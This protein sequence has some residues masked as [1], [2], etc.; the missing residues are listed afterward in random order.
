MFLKNTKTKVLD[1]QKDGQWASYKAH[2]PKKRK[3]HV[4]MN[5]DDKL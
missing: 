1:R 3:A 4:P 5:E 2:V